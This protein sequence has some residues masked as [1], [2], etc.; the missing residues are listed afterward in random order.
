M[1]KL[2]H[3]LRNID[4][5]L[6]LIVFIA[7]FFRFYQPGLYDLWL[8]EIVFQ[9]TSIRLARHGEW[10]L[11]GNRSQFA[12][13]A[14]HSPLTN[15]L[16]A[17]PYL[18]SP[19]PQVGRI[20]MGLFGVGTVL[21][22]YFV[23]KRYFGQSSAL[24]S[25]LFV[26]V[27]PLAIDISRYALNP[28]FAPL[29]LVL[30]VYTG[31]RGYY[32]GEQT[33]QVLHWLLLSAIIQSQAAL[34]I[35]LPLSFILV[36]YHWLTVAE[37]RVHILKITGLSFVLMVITFLPWI[38]GIIGVREGWHKLPGLDTNQGSDSL[39]FSVPDWKILWEGLANLAGGANFHLN[40]LK[41]NEARA[42]WW[43]PLWLN[44]VF[45]MQTVFILS[46]AIWTAI[47]Y[48]RSKKLH[49]PTL[50]IVSY[51]FLPLSYYFFAETKPIIPSYMLATTYG[52]LL[53]IGIGIAE[54]LKRS[55]IF[56]II[57]IIFVVSHIWM[58]SSYLNWYQVDPGRLS[59]H[60]MQGLV[61]E[62]AKDGTDVVM[63][64]NPGNERQ[65]KRF[66]WE[67]YW[68]ILGEQYPLRS[69]EN[70][71]AFPIANEGST[72]VAP[73][74]DPTIPKFFGEGE[75]IPDFQRKFR[76]IFVKPD[77]LP[78]ANYL[79]LDNPVFGDLLKINGIVA[80]IP[81]AGEIWDVAI[82]W[83]VLKQPETQYQF[84][85]RLVG[86][87]GQHYGQVDGE[88]LQLDIW[89]VDDTVLTQ[90]SMMIN[91][92][93]LADENLSI[94]LL[95]YSLPEIQNVQLVNSFDTILT[96]NPTQ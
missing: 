17:L 89:Q 21:A 44:N 86:A 95:V 84:S 81:S 63:F 39:I 59:L 77:D 88:T 43:A 36:L 1:V 20:F 50:F 56:V 75:I 38:I 48:I 72:L 35:I 27:F 5:W 26:A 31:L 66:E 7:S 25:A 28:N 6:V 47:K 22:S 67:V 54:L 15:Y 78:Q 53:L 32:E 73:D 16:L 10:T 29:L 18:F 65:Y 46:F 85:V 76:H 42:S 45:K 57:P 69:V 58:M 40:T 92:D 74:Y 93:L 87:E 82:I 68:R 91:E 2:F 30:W 33:S 71:H 13:L 49:F 11:V 3:R 37:Y 80:D 41:I 12:G 70:L 8:D 60:E 94:Q 19:N 90:L 34:V 14:A 83:Q 9:D 23:V 96:L 62:W 79:P 24:W 55:R 64:D 51:I 61:R 52:S 4:R